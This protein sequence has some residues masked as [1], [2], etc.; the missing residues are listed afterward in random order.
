MMDVV[1]RDHIRP[2]HKKLVDYGGKKPDTQK[3]TP[4]AESLNHVVYIRYNN[5]GTKPGRGPKGLAEL[6]DG[7]HLD[8]AKLIR[9]GSIFLLN[10]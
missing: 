2:P 10:S 9:L 8:S 6:V 3:H 5:I 1:T 4:E 7:D